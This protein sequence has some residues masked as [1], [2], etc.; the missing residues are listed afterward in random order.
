MMGESETTL[1]LSDRF[2]KVSTCDLAAASLAIERRLQLEASAPC[3]GVRAGR[4]API[5]AIT[6]H[7]WHI[8]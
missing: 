1:L 4:R 5:L 2:V 8:P 3:A 6:R 7:R